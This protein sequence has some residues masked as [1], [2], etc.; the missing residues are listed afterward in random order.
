MPS[1]GRWR[2]EGMKSMFLLRMLMGRKTV[3]L[4]SDWQ[5]IWK[6]SRSRYFPCPLARRLYWAPALERAL[7]SGIR[8]FDLIHLHS[9]RQAVRHETTSKLFTSFG[10]GLN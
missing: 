3:P 10:S 4:Q 9:G 7:E 1:A 6:V 5:L 8:K 2:R